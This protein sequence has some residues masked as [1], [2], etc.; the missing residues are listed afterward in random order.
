MKLSKPGHVSDEQPSIIGDPTLP[1]GFYGA[2]T[3]CIIFNKENNIYSMPDSFCCAEN[4]ILEAADLN[5]AS[6]II[7]RAE[8]TFNIDLG[9]KLKRMEYS[10]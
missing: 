7:G 1:S 9:R 8:Q 10:I 3:V 6:A 4:M 2:P 5:I